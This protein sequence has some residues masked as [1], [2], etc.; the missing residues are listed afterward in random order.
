MP[1]NTN[2][3]QFLQT[4]PAQITPGT[5]NTDE[6][7]LAETTWD[8]VI[9]GLTPEGAV[10]SNSFT[11]AA[12]DATAATAASITAEAVVAADLD[13]DASTTLVNT[14]PTADPTTDNA[15]R[16]NTAD[17]TWYS[18][19]DTG[20][21]WV[22]LTADEAAYVAL[23]SPNIWLGIGGR[24]GSGDVDTNVEV[25]AYIQD[26]MGAAIPDS[27]DILFSN[28]T[29][30]QKVSTFTA[31]VGASD[32]ERK[33]HPV[34]PLITESGLRGGGENIPLPY[35]TGNSAM[36]KNAPGAVSVEGNLMFAGTGDGMEMV[37]R[38]MTQD[39]NPTV[40][41][42]ASRTLAQLGAEQTVASNYNLVTS[43]AL[44]VATEI[45]AAGETLFTNL[46][47]ISGLDDGIADIAGAP[48]KIPVRLDID[49]SVA[50]GSGNVGVIQL[51]G[52]DKDRLPLQET[53]VWS[54][55]HESQKTR[56]YFTGLTSYS[57]SGWASA[58]TFSVKYTDTARKVTFTP[59][60]QELVAFWFV[61]LVRGITPTMFSGV[62]GNNFS[63]TLGRDTPIEWTVECLGKRSWPN[64]NLRG[65]EWNAGSGDI[66]NANR[67]GRRVV[68]DNSIG[69]ADPEIF[70]G[71]Q[72]E[73]S[74][75]G[76]RMSL[77]DATMSLNQNLENSG[78]ITGDRYEESPPFRGTDRE[79]MVDGTV[80][81][82]PENNLSQ[83]YL[84]NETLNDVR[85][86]L[87]NRPRGGFPW[88]TRFLFPTTQI[89]TNP[90]PASP[91]DGR[92]TQTFNLKC[93]T[94]G[95]GGGPKDYS[96]ETFVTNYKAVR[97][98]A[99]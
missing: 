26:N 44:S 35:K 70:T 41:P 71:W 16:F 30:L 14:A 68:L 40:A 34:Q 19:D 42:I 94:E 63:V 15:Y 95:V 66:T 54:S 4:D 12:T 23:A 10:T 38:M 73:L 49:P 21:A 75:G 76:T 3:N 69:F 18:W 9:N 82:A 67:R 60:D 36:T 27:V 64:R 92:I 37:Y 29:A 11:P 28:G 13:G 99:A 50:P 62:V 31:A 81:Y 83:I 79:L 89:N 56:N 2:Q 25:A 57:T 86:S 88:L 90:D 53:L 77:I 96:I 39:R 43:D 8:E 78:V 58:G 17:D 61:R 20:D 97:E 22:T 46:Q 6:I 47:S 65:E 1:V 52:Y 48:R 32:A 80:V 7:L 33:F 45:T 5:A 93:F 91:R 87:R 51:N 55:G 59:Q 24:A 74:I 72:C 84:N 85:L 98:F